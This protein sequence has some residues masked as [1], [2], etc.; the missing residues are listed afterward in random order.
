MMFSSSFFI[1]S[2]AFFQFIR[3]E[4]SML[5]NTSRRKRRKWK[6]F[7]SFRLTNLRFL[8]VF[9]FCYEPEWV[10]WVVLRLYPFKFSSIAPSPQHIFMASIREQR[11][12]FT[13]LSCAL[14]FEQFKLNSTRQYLHKIL[15]ITTHKSTRKKAPERRKRDGWKKNASSSIFSLFYFHTFTFLL[16]RGREIL[17][18]FFV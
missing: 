17:F 6:N 1:F 14:K 15:V 18:S 13:F 9:I 2:F 10:A 12:K 16:S 8:F 5:S 3:G 7:V 4:A 11:R